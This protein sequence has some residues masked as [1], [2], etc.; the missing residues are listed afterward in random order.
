MAGE[1]RKV[2]SFTKKA[3]TKKQARQWKHVYN[4]QKSRGLSEGQAIASA[5]SVVGRSGRGKRRGRYR[6]RERSRGR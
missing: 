1:L 2:R 5:S 3:R 6:R 4:S